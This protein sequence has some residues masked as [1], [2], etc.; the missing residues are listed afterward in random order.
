VTQLNSHSNEPP[1]LRSSQSS[2]VKGTDTIL[3][4]DDSIMA[5]RIDT[6]S[7]NWSLVGVGYDFSLVERFVI[8]V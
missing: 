3:G 8:L 1:S 2:I 6:I 5:S 4:H 7:T